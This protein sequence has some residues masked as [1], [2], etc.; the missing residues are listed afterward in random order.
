MD[1]ISGGRWLQRWAPSR[2]LRGRLNAAIE[3]D[4]R[5]YLNQMHLGNGDTV[6]ACLGEGWRFSDSGIVRSRAS[7]GAGVTTSARGS[8]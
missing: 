6:R 8:A 4:G 5:V 1:R 7:A 3:H 2:P